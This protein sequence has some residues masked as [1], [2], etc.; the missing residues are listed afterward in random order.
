MSFSAYSF[1]KNR[2]A[3]SE[4]SPEEE[5][6]FELYTTQIALENE[7]R[8]TDMLCKSNTAAFYRLSKRVQAHSFDCLQGCIVNMKYNPNRGKKVQSLKNEIN[9]YIKDLGVDYQTAKYL[10]LNQPSK[11]KV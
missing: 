1:I 11:Q 4:I 10:V 3:G 7:L 8:A 5:N 2:S 9:E 6:E